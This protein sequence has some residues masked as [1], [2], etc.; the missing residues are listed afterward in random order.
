MHKDVRVGM[1]SLVSTVPA[2]AFVVT[3]LQVSR[4]FLMQ[5][6]AHLAMQNG[7]AINNNSLTTHLVCVTLRVAKRVFSLQQRQILDCRCTEVEV[8]AELSLRN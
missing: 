3:S 7:S 2:F 6:L 5:T 8:K 4:P 1:V